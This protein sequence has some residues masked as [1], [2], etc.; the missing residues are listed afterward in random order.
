MATAMAVRQWLTGILIAVVVVPIVVIR[1]DFA[2]HGPRVKA[3]AGFTG[4]VSQAPRISVWRATGTYTS[5]KGHLGRTEGEQITRRW[6]TSRRCSHGE[7]AYFITREMANLP[8]TT[9][10]LTPQRD[11]WHATFPVLV[12]SCSD[13]ATWEQQT[14]FIFRFTNGGAAAQAHEVHHSYAPACGYGVS[15]VDWQATLAANPSNALNGDGPVSRGKGPVNAIGERAMAASVQ[16]VLKRRTRDLERQF[17][18]AVDRDVNLDPVL[19]SCR[20]RENAPSRT[21]SA[22]ECWT[23]ADQ[24]RPPTSQVVLGVVVTD[25]EGRCWRGVHF[26]YA[27]GRH[28]PAR[29]YA[30][31][32]VRREL[33]YRPL[34]GC[35]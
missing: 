24:M 4:D 14:S 34:R 7:C 19:T 33:A 9:A 3:P 5:I 6:T 18:G 12:L 27:L 11:G 8:P 28:A 35:A 21:G 17:G 29:D 31:A 13:S 20:S 10:R 15:R 26:G 32:D 25:I 23:L 1:S 30:E 22:F 16:D 2:M